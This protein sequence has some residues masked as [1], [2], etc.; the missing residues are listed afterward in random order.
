MN[1]VSVF[2]PLVS[3]IGLNKLSVLIY[4]RVYMEPDLIF[5]SEVHARRFDAQMGWLKALCNVLPL[6]EAVQRLQAGTLPRRAACVTFDDGY[7]DNVEVAL[8]IL[9]RH[10]VPA[11]FFISS[12]FL[13]GGRMWNDTVIEAI[14][15]V[16]GAMVDLN[17]LGLGKH[18]VG[19]MATRNTTIGAIIGSLKY[20]PQEARNSQ[21]DALQRT[22]AECLPDNLM[23]R[24][25]QVRELADAGMTVGAHTVSHPILARLP[26]AEARREI[27]VG[28]ETLE[29]I[30]GREVT[31]FAYPNGKPVDDYGLKHVAMVRELGF[32]GAVCTAWGSAS[33]LDDIFQLPRFTPWDKTALRFSAR[34]TGNLLR[35]AATLQTA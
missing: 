18:P 26:A 34:F 2:R 5:P 16:S 3:A 15:R 11:T 7:A 24:A 17:H 20:L 35:Q 33:R 13:D 28:R 1:P 22:V 30:T 19:T 14:R 12:G 10:G 27:R 23:M 6:E 25:E 29:A 21:V 31:L 8:P 32:Q 4:H 9:K